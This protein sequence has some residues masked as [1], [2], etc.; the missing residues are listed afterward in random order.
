M[1]GSASG[2]N[3]KKQD[4]YGG[5]KF[6]VMVFFLSLDLGLNSTLDYDSYSEGKKG[7]IVLGL[8][9]L[10]IVVQISVFLLLFLTVADT[11]LFR[12]GLL[13]FLLRRIRLVLFAHVL[14]FVITVVT[15]TARINH[16]GNSESLMSLTTSTSFVALSIIQKI[17]KFEFCTVPIFF[18]LP[19]QLPY[20]ITV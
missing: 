5:N 14:Y 10:Q 6:Y 12:V 2:A 13:G 9:G 11:F 1:R 16:Y 8:L 4:T 19:F 17:R 20:F 18:F 7:F 3:F 15:G